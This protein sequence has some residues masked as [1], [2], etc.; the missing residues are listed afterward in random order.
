M[1]HAYQPQMLK[2]CMVKDH[3]SYNNFFN[4]QGDCSMNDIFLKT[5]I[6]HFRKWKTEI[7]NRLVNM[8]DLIMETDELLENDLESRVR[9]IM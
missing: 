8:F 9:A 6:V 2:Q 5:I 4:K 7:Q 1:V 3:K